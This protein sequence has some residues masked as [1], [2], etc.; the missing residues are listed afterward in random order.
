MSKNNWN[1][2]WREYPWRGLKHR[3]FDGKRYVICS[4][5]EQKDANK[6]AQ[7][8]R[9]ADGLARITKYKPGVDLYNVWGHPN[10]NRNA[11]YVIYGEMP[12]ELGSPE[13]IVWR[14]DNG[15]R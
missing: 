3:T 5:S 11:Y 6:L 15:W 9:N 13:G 14:K 4:W 12:N 8:I 1:L 10:G 7:K 2:D